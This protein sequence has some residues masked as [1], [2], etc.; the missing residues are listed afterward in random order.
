MDSEILSKTNRLFWLGRYVERTIIEIEVM[1]DA[2]DRAI[3]REPFDFQTFCEQLEI[4]CP[5][6]TSD[7]FILGFLFDEDYPCSVISTLGYAYDN[8]IVLREVITSAAL[9]YIQMAVNIMQSAASGVAPMLELQSVIDMLYAFRGCCD[10][11]VLDTANR[12]TVKCGYS[13]ERI[14]MCVRLNYH[15]HTLDVEFARLQTRLRN[16]P[17]RRD[18]KRLMALLGL[19]P[20]PDPENN[21]DLLLDCIEGLFIDR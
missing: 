1:M 18:G 12:Y 4:E 17:M 21:R 10:D 2:Y 13:I 14:D 11:H 3:D 20:N 6:E 19:A 15:V 5:Y 16:T 9:S 8:A 7:E